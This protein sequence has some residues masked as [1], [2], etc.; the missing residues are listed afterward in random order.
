MEES[1]GQIL[2]VEKIVYSLEITRKD[3]SKYFCE[4]E[5]KFRLEDC[6]GILHCLCSKIEAAQKVNYIYEC[7]R[8]YSQYM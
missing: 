6:I 2:T 7:E 1:N 8:F 5:E 4:D 3:L